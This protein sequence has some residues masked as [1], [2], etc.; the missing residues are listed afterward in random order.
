MASLTAE[1][2]FFR[3]AWPCADIRLNTRK[4]TEDQYSLLKNFRDNP[5]QRPSRELLIECFP[6]AARSLAEAPLP[7]YN[8]DPWSLEHVRNYWRYHHKGKSPTAI[9]LVDSV[10]IDRVWAHGKN[11]QVIVLLNPYSI[12][13]ETDDRIVAHQ[14]CAIE[15]L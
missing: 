13:V 3:Y 10:G 5:H 9:L 2:L 1:H 8:A 6:D 11:S 4:I 14:Q 15:K 7:L 12:D